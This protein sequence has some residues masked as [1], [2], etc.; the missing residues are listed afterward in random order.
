MSWFGIAGLAGGGFHRV[1]ADLPDPAGDDRGPVHRRQHHRRACARI[2][3]DK[4]GDMWKQQVIVE[5]RPGIPG[6]TGVAKAAP[7]GYTLML[8]S[9]A[10]DRSTALISKSVQFDI[11]SRFR[12]CEPS[13][14]CRWQRWSRSIH[15]R[16]R[17][18][19]YR[20]AS[21]EREAGPAQFLLSRRASPASTY[22]AAEVFKQQARLPSSNVPYRGAGKPCDRR[23]GARR[24]QYLFLARSRLRRK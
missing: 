21:C 3:A 11:R 4:L 13:G 18:S 22:L 5:N 1:G 14:R 12:R 9:M 2:L 10:H 17:S 19:T 7:D 20:G 23:R 15:P 16:N 6:T 24:C 8:T